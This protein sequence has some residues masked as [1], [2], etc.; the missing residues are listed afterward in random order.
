MSTNLFMRSA[1]ARGFTLVEMIIALV[2]TGIVA[3]MVG[4]FIRTPIRS[5]ADIARRTALVDA[6]DTALRRMSREIHLALPN[7][8]RVSADQRAI[9]FFPTRSGGRYRAAIDA[10]PAAPVSDP[11][12]FAAND[13][14]FD[15]LGDPIALTAGDQIV[16]YNLG[17]PGADAYAGNTGPSHNRRAYSGAGGTLAKIPLTSANPFPLD[18][19][20]RR[21]HVVST[22]VTYICDPVARTLQRYW[23][24]AVQA[25]SSAVDTVAELDALVS[26]KN[27]TRSS[28]LVA[29][30]VDSCVFTYEA[31]LTQSNGLVAM[32]LIMRKDDESV[33]LIHQVHVNNVP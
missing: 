20:G 25:D 13:T 32:R 15:V 26:P 21:F 28:A 33:S 1:T 22:P 17:I 6:A 24:Y 5:Y 16:I 18:S 12:D 10:T 19:P 9:E 30:N 31:G 11:L 4:F 23:G 27:A 14:A 3:A 8:A 29:E 7:S 2:I